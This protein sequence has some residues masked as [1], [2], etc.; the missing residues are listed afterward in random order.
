M[1]GSI[2]ERLLEA[3]LAP[4]REDV[5]EIKAMLTTAQ[6]RGRQRDEDIA[7]MKVEIAFLK[8]VVFGVAS[9]AAGAAVA[10]ILKYLGV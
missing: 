7:A 5:R 8:R 9:V 10:V 4:I 6:E 3:H 2:D 1:T